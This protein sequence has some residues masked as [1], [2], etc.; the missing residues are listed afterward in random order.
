MKINRLILL[1]ILGLFLVSTSCKEW[2]DV[3][4]LYKEDL[5]KSE[6][7]LDGTI[8]NDKNAPYYKA[9]REY[10]ETDHQVVFGWF[11]NWTGTGVSSE[12]MM[13]GLPDSTDMIS[14]WGNWQEPTDE[15]LADLKYCQEVKGLK[16]MAC[17]LIFDIG[18]AITPPIPDDKKDTYDWRRWRHEFWGFEE[19]N[20]EKEIE[21]IRKYANALCDVIDKYNYDGFDIDA[22]PNYA[23][24]FET[25]KELWRE[26]YRIYEFI[27]TLAK[28]LG[29]SSGSGKLLVID[30]E[31]YAIAPEQGKH[32]DYFIVQAYACTSDR[33]LDSRLKMIINNFQEHMTPQ[34]VAKKYIVTENFENYALQGGVNFVDRYGKPMKSLEGMARY[35]PII[36][37]RPVDKGG[38][39]T[40]HM[41]YEYAVDGYAESY[42]FLRNAIRIMNPPIN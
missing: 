22:E 3:D 17:A 1:S 32:F 21:A 34:Q 24:P 35:T 14:M 11:G 20:K 37:G 19:G 13:R 16:A 6:Y 10:K 23:Q 27:E 7:A 33:N 41:E 5:T 31:P 29:P 38:C 39:G 9:L 40:Y 8:E 30:G 26:D 36:D 15:M 18:D 42:P 28:R 12:N 25:Y 4:N 2:T